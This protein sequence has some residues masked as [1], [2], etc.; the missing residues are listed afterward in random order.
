M[1]QSDQTRMNVQYCMGRVTGVVP[2]RQPSRYGWR[3]IEGHQAAYLTR[4]G[5]CSPRITTASWRGTHVGAFYR[6]PHRFYKQNCAGI[7]AQNRPDVYSPSPQQHQLGWKV[8]WSTVDVGAWMGALGSAA[9]FVVTQEALLV[10]GPLILPLIALYASNERNR[11]DAKAAQ[12]RVQQQV[13]QAVRH[14]VA[15][16]EEG[17]AEMAEEISDAVKNM[18]PALDEHDWKGVEDRLQALDA[19]LEM[20]K[21]SVKE[22]GEGSKKNI[23]RSTDAVGEGLKK[24]RIDIRNDL[25]EATSEE[26]AALA[27][28][29]TRL[30]VC[31]CTYTVTCSKDFSENNF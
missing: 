7:R 11:I 13:T 12:E 1:M 14:I 17:A 5:V 26:V 25:Q 20:L 18:K 31:L 23:R 15:L 24:L 2:L 22:S 6:L 16:S 19:S 21:E 29:D 8:F 4:L 27:R 9:A 3:Q 28:L 30:S 10:A